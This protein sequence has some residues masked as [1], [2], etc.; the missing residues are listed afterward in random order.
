MK[1]GGNVMVTGGAGFIGSALVRALVKEGSDVTVLDNM[2]SGDPSNLADVEGVRLVRK[3]IRDK[4]IA[5]FLKKEGIDYLFHLAAE[6]YI[7]H[8]YDRPHD[9]FD[10]NAFGTLNV[11]MAAKEAGVERILQYSTSEVYGTA[12]YVPMDENHPLFPQST[13]AV[14]KLAA[15]RL[16]FTLFHE[17]GLPVIIM[18]QFNCYGPRETHPYV[19]PEIITQ[20]SKSS[21][22]KLGNAA[23]RRDLTYVD[24]AVQVPIGLMKRKSAV[25]GIFNSGAGKSYSVE[26]L[27]HLIA[28]IMGVKNLK[29]ETE[30]GRF[31][32]LD[33]ELLEC[34]YFKVNR[35][36]G[37]APK[38][39]IREGLGRTV[40]YFRESGNAWLWEKKIAKESE[41]WK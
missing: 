39:D 4:G 27:A 19:I 13:Y 17:R 29:M 8:C 36:L 3:D 7:P 14:S 28:D 30:R 10:V 25:G 16:C 2:C 37:W 15:D 1:L 24:D 34:N 21:T 35:L 32:P 18:R 40:E 5:A 12:K 9:F 31:R 41:L 6:P 20:L 11:M 33:V 38:T 22:L 23:A 26:E